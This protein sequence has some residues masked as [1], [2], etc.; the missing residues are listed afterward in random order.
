M[1]LTLELSGG[2]INLALDVTRYWTGVPFSH[3]WR[4]WMDRHLVG[5]NHPWG[6]CSRAGG[7]FVP[8]RA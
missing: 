6:V 5:S 7:E 1:L 2:R 4:S 8:R 3:A